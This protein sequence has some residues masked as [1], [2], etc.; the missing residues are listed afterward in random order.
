MR[1]IKIEKSTEQ[2][3]TLGHNLKK[4]ENIF[5]HHGHFIKSLRKNIRSTDVWTIISKKHTEETNEKCSMD[6]TPQTQCTQP[7]RQ[8]RVQITI[9]LHPYILKDHVNYHNDSIVLD[10]HL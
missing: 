6:T 2:T 3:E 7:T 9:P 8:A 4:F 10:S 5:L 1:V